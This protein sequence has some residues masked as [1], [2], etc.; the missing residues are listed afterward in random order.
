L[1]AVVK[2]PPPV[3]Y[4]KYKAQQV[5]LPAEILCYDKANSNRGV[6]ILV[7]PVEDG[8]QAHGKRASD[9]SNFGGSAVRILQL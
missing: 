2:V 5:V 7:F 4:V 9:H 3:G 8:K 1:L 6:E